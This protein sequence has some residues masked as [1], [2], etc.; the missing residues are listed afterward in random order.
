MT[1]P[2]SF[3]L[4][5]HLI[6]QKHKDT[7]DYITGRNIGEEEA[8]TRKWCETCKIWCMNKYSLRQHF[9]GKKH[10]DNV[11]EL[12]LGLGG[13][14]KGPEKTIQVK[15]YCELCELW[16][17]DEYAFNQHLKGKRHILNLHAFE[18]KRT[19]KGKG[20]AVE[21]SSYIRKN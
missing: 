1:C 4:K 2:S 21:R 7:L 13:G 17:M 6:G 18:E 8:N 19:E 20:L 12:Q 11:Q 14:K 9:M 10:Q 3:H 15:Q 5:Q 16:C